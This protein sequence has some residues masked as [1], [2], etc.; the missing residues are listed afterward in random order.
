MPPS[1]SSV[2]DATIRLADLD[3]VPAILEISNHY[4]LHTPANFAVEPEPIEDW[5]RTWRDMHEWYP[6]LV[7]VDPAGAVIGFA[8]SSPW[9][10][11]GAYHWSVEVSVYLHASHR[12]RGIGR[13]LYDRLFAIIRAQGRHAAVAG[14]T[15]PNEASV[16]LHESMGMQRTA[17][18]PR[19][20]WKFGCW[21]D[22]G[23]WIVALQPEDV[24]P[25]ATRPV[26]EAIAALDSSQP[27]CSDGA[28]S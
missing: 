25:G 19:I 12:S 24:E 16:R 2:L 28:R 9:N 4:A 5:Q 17:L 1:R 11:R 8:K 13:A 23:Y 14:I 10:R 18:Y 7:A 26:A 21:Y 6:W 27:G 22:V 15:L 3:D 20:G